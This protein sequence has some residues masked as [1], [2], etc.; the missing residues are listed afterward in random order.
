[1]VNIT[2]VYDA[3]TLYGVADNLLNDHSK[4]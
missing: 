1:M 4:K 3:S 2:M